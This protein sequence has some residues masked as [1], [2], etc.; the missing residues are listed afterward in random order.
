M[1]NPSDRRSP[2]AG[3]EAPTGGALKGIHLDVVDSTNEVAKRMVQS[4][5]IDGPAYVLAREQSQGKG[6]RGRRWLSPRDA[7]I[8]V[9]IVQT[10]VRIIDCRDVNLTDLTLAAG[11]ACVEAIAE[12]TG[13]RVWL[14]PVND[15]YADGG[16]LGGILTEAVIVQG[17]VRAIVVGIGINVHAAELNLDSG[18]VRPICLEEL[19][20]R[21]ISRDDCDRLLIALLSR[22]SAAIELIM[23]GQAAEI[24]SC[25]ER[26]KLP[27]TTLPT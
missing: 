21:M 2:N 8:Y 25:W 9:S 13:I 3:R 27:G 6:S 14:K 23:N 19:D 11:V 15:L 5:E 7:G 10:P 22:G 4:G 24:R 1:L 20:V 26:H 17:Q 12:T 18:D 16:K